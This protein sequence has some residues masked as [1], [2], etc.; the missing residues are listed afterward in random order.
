[1]IKTI[2]PNGPLG[3]EMTE[4]CTVTQLPLPCFTEPHNLDVLCW[5]FYNLL[6]CYNKFILCCGTTAPDLHNLQK[7][8]K[9]HMCGL[10]LALIFVLQI[11]PNSLARENKYT[12]CCRAMNEKGL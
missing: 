8:S 2:Y 11:A 7:S 9:F 10:S 5:N 6:V 1:M 3:Y 12:M 4:M